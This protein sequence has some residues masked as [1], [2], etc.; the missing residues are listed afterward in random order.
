MRER[1][2]ELW[3]EKK[4][5]KSF[6]FYVLSFSGINIEEDFA[7]FFP[8]GF[9]QDKYLCSFCMVVLFYHLVILFIWFCYE[10]KY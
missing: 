9:S 1:E 4:E 8:L 6:G 2:K 5:D 3:L 10:I 7:V